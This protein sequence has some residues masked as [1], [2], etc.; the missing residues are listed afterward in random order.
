MGKTGCA[1]TVSGLKQHRASTKVTI[2]RAPHAPWRA[3]FAQTL[4]I[5][6]ARK[7]N[8]TIESYQSTACAMVRLGM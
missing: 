2:H 6:P 5:L 1:R 3:A 8:P 4:Q 7:R